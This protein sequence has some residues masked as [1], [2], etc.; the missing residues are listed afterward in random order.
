MKQFDYG[1]PDGVGTP[2]RS[3]GEDAVFA[4]VDRWLAKKIKTFRAVEDP[5]HKEMR[6]ALDV[7]EARLK[8]RQKFEY[9]LSVMFYAESFGNLFGFFVWSADESYGAESQ[10]D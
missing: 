1:Q 9:T 7:E 3:G 2:W 10:H 6:K 8:F 4:G 5:K